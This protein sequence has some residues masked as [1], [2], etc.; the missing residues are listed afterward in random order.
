[1]RRVERGEQQRE[2]CFLAAGE[3]RDLCLGLR[4][5]KAEPCEQRAEFRGRR[6]GAFALQVL[7][8]RLVEVQFVHLVLGEV[9][10]AQLRRAVHSAVHQR[11]AVGQQL[12]QGRLALAVLAQKRDAVVL[13]DAQVEPP[14]HGGVAVAGGAVLDVDDGRRQFVGLREGEDA[15]GHLLGRGDHVHALD[16]LQPGL[17]LLGLAG[18]GAEAVDEGLQVGAAVLLL[19]GGG[20]ELGALFGAQLDEAV[21]GRAVVGQLAVLEVEDRADGAVQEA[22]VVGDDDDRVRVAREVGFEPERAFE[23]EVVGRLVE[24]QQVGLGEEHAGE[25]H[26]HPPAAGIG[27]AGARV[28]LRVE[29]QALEDRGGAGLRAPGVD[30]GEAG[31]DLGD[32]VAGGG[33]LFGKKR[34]ALGVGGEH[35]VEDRGL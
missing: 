24:Q 3:A 17:R 12:R 5:I 19:S 34:R 27:G 16:H 25:R 35:G 10:D 33:V 1:M 26:A 30:V 28:F 21:V 2:P 18:L 15:L 9:A 31:L 4:G 8:R 7:E 14:Q 13:V 20:G 11:Q 23:V 6:V 22:A 32:A 29:T